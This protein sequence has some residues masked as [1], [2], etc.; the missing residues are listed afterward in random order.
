MFSK[1][2]VW[3]PLNSHALSLETSSSKAKLEVNID[4]E[5][6][7]RIHLPKHFRDITK[8]MYLKLRY[9]HFCNRGII[10]NYTSLTKLLRQF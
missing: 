3:K 1:M 5:F 2:S 9:G 6:E 4:Q 10:R 7:F 8:K